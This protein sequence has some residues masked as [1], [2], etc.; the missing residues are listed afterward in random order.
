ML[1]GPPGNCPACACVK[2][3]LGTLLDRL[4]SRRENCNPTNSSEHIYYNLIIFFFT[5]DRVSDF[6][7]GCYYSEPSTYTSDSVVHQRF[8][9]A[10]FL[11]VR[12][13]YSCSNRTTASS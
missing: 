12:G 5:A 6:S 4:G 9:A 10:S 1:V 2:T 8:L 13:F 7:D 11:D 3:A